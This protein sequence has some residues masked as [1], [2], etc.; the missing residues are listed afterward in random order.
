MQDL[1]V[2]ILG[3]GRMGRERARCVSALGA[4][5]TA[6]YDPDG[7]RAA[8]LA[9]QFGSAAVT[10]EPEIPWRSLDAVFF[11]TPP[12]C[13]DAQALAAIGAG[14]AFLAEKPVGLSHQAAARVAS[15]LERA[16]VV[17]A[18]GYMNRC[19]LSIRLT[20]DLLADT[21]LLGLAGFW[22]CRQY[23][24]PWWLDPAASGGPLN[25]QATHLF[26]LCRVFGGEIASVQSVSA[27]P[28]LGAAESLGCAST[29][30]FHS[31]AIGT[32]FYS[33][34]SSGK[35]IGLHLFTDRGSIELAGWDFR[36]TTNTIDGSM[37]E[38]AG[39]EDVFLLETEQFLHAVRTGRPEDVPCDWID[40]MRTQAAVDAARA[41]LDENRV[42]ET[43]VH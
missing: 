6:V 11:C 28:A 3:C 21:R 42:C 40:A 24:V 20:R 26:D 14:V 22:V 33:C 41:C 36:M 7:E 18:I 4:T 29:V 2:A 30:Q 38:M 37:P 10:S 32:V 12:Q 17:N 5:I 9:G 15:A 35:S 1:N 23:T 13:R 31:G 19:R 43:A 34:E 39:E 8:A 16:P 27:N 25:E